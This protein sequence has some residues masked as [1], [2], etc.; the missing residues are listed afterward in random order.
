MPSRNKHFK[1]NGCAESHN[2]TLNL[3]V[4][5]RLTMNL[6]TNDNRKS[7][8]DDDDRSTSLHLSF[9]L[10]SFLVLSLLIGAGGGEVWQYPRSRGSG[11]SR[12]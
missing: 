7:S 6:E 5:L 4:Y 10:P 12:V 11:S 2:H 8:G 9:L 3:G 1:A